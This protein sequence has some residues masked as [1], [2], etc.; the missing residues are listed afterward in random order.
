MAANNVETVMKPLGKAMKI[1]M[2]NL[3]SETDT[4]QSFLQTYR[5]TPHSATGVA[6]GN[7]IFRDGYRSDLPRRSL[8]A[9]RIVQAQQLDA[10]LKEERKAAYNSSIHTKAANFKVNDQVLVRNF[11]KK[12]KFEPYFLPERF[13]V[14]DTLA[15]GKIILVQSSRTGRYLK[16]HPNDLKLYDGE[17][18]SD[19][20]RESVSEAALLVLEAWREA[21]EHLAVVGDTDEDNTPVDGAPGANDLAPVPQAPGIPLRRSTRQ[22]VPNRR[23]FNEQYFNS[24]PH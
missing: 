21:F 18:S 8:S 7:M 17:F 11:Y 23:Y 9:D 19:A 24:L 15:N 20:G 4:L 13:I 14:T 3:A 5:D 22:A 2:N 12:S 16:R 1:G 10:S 6:P